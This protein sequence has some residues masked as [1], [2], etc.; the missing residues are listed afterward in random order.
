MSISGARP[1]IFQ[2]LAH[3]FFRHRH[4]AG[5]GGQARLGEVQEYRATAACDPGP[6]VVVNFNNEIIKMILPPQPVAG[7][8]GGHPDRLVIAA[9]CRV[10]APG[11]E[12]A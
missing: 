5:G 7:L 12:A 2:E 8:T 1:K 11:V 9:V 3:L 10:L 4:A 6:R